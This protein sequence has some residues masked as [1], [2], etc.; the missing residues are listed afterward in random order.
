[1][2]VC[3]EQ[4]L[5]SPIKS[6]LCLL[7]MESPQRK[8][9][10]GPP[11]ENLQSCASQTHLPQL[12]SLISVVLGNLWGCC[13]ELLSH[14]QRSHSRFTVSQDVY[15]HGPCQ[16]HRP[17][18]ENPC[19]GNKRQNGAMSQIAMAPANTHTLAILGRYVVLLGVTVHFLLPSDGQMSPQTFMDI[20]KDEGRFGYFTCL[21]TFRVR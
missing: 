6:L 10:K 7:G 20:A 5:Q 1:M 21:F 14:S 17:R 4:T 2:D 9:L 15:V 12:W 13:W 18:A 8:L 16:V 11:C 3:L 19:L